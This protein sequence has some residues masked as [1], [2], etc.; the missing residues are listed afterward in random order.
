[1]AI[2]NELIAREPEDPGSVVTP[3]LTTSSIVGEARA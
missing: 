3:H 2:A 1:M